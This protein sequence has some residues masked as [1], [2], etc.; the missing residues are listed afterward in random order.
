M[1]PS[2][3]VFSSDTYQNSGSPEAKIAKE[4]AREFVYTKVG[5]P[6]KTSI[7][8]ETEI[9][10]KLSQEIELKHEMLL[11]SMCNRLNVTATNAHKTFAEIADEIFCDGSINWGR[12]VV[13][14]TFAGKL[15]IHCK[16]SK[17]EN[18][19]DKIVN[20]VGNFVAK[21]QLWIKETGRGWNGFIEQFK[22]TKDDQKLWFQGLL[23]TTVGLGTIAAALY[24]KS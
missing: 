7:R 23:A 10:L 15:A 9:V 22:D 17:M 20:W 21:K 16:L 11:K 1:R 18:M 2:K 6:L 19:D 4:I 8:K 3:E 13:L 14:Y 5:R 12:L 24:I